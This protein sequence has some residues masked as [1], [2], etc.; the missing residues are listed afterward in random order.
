MRSLTHSKA[1]DGAEKE[2]RFTAE[3]R[4]YQGGSSCATAASKQRVVF[5]SRTCSMA[6]SQLELSDFYADG[7]V[8]LNLYLDVECR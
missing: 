1:E 4:V 2:R 7:E 5:L 3:Y 8:E 6:G